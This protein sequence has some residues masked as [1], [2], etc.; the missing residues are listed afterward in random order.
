ME[1]QPQLTMLQKTLLNVEGLGRELDPNLDLWKTAR[2]F[3]EKWLKEQTGPKNIIK[4]LKKEF[5][6]FIDII[7]KLPKLIEAYLKNNQYVSIQTDLNNA[8]YKLQKLKKITD[9]LSIII[10]FIIICWILF[11]IYY[12]SHLIP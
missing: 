5:P 2:P 10:L 11:F 8:S 12:G 9:L 4:N 6:D 7:P 3:L 1:G